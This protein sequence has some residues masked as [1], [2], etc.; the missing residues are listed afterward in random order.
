MHFAVYTEVQHINSSSWS[1]FILN[2]LLEYNEIQELGLWADTLHGSTRLLVRYENHKEEK[3]GRRK[4][5]K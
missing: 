1:I 2:F 4:K 5:H 3:I